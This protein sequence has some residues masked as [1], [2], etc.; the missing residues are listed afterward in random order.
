MYKYNMCMLSA[1]CHYMSFEIY[2]TEE[3]YYDYLL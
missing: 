1:S 2:L 3:N